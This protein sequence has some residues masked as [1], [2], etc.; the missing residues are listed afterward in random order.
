CAARLKRQRGCRSYSRQAFELLSTRPSQRRARLRRVLARA[1]PLPREHREDSFLVYAETRACRW[2]RGERAR[3]AALLSARA[4]AAAT[5][6]PQCI[7]KEQARPL[8]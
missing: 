6:P 1:P 2:S 5:R 7:R 3:Q 8:R 4:D